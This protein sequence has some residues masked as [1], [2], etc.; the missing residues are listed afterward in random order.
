MPRVLSGKPAKGEDMVGGSGSKTTSNGPSLSGFTPHS[1]GWQQNLP[2]YRYYIPSTPI[3]KELLSRLKRRSS[4]RPDRPER[5][6]LREFF[7][8]T[9]DQQHI[10]AS[11]AHACVG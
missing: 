8:V 4:R 5:V 3:V 6:D 1:F 11:P 9:S 10:N 2:D 7:P